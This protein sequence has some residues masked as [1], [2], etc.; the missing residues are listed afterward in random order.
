MLKTITFRNRLIALA[1][2]VSISASVMADEPRKIDVPAGE[3]IVALQK[4]AEQ[5]GVEFIYS[6]EQLK[7]YHTGGVKGEYEPKEAI[8]L[9]LRGTPLEMHVDPNGAILIA[10]PRNPE[11]GARGQSHD[12]G[13]QSAADSFHLTQ[14]DQT[15]P[16]EIASVEK[17]RFEEAAAATPVQLEEIVVTGSHI[18]GVPSVSS[19]IEL[20]QE[21]I[22]AEGVSNLGDAVRL[23]PQNFS[24]GQNP[25]VARGAATSTPSNQNFTG[26]SSINLRGLGPDAT[27]TLLNGHRLAYDSSFQAVDISTIPLDAVDRIEIVADGASAIYGSDA[28]AG[29]ANIILKRDYQ[30]ITTSARIG[31]ATD[32]GDFQQQYNVVGGTTWSS[33]GFIATYSYE[34]DTALDANDRSFTRYLPEPYTLFPGQTVNALSLSGHQSLNDSLTFSIDNLFSNRESR[35]VYTTTTE[36]SSASRTRSFTVAPAVSYKLP[37]SWSLSAYGVYGQDHSDIG[38]Q[39]LGPFPSQSE[40]CF[41]NGVAT[42][43]LS[44]KGDILKLPAG[45]VTIA[46]GGG[47]RRDTFEQTFLDNSGQAP[48]SGSRH[49][50]YGYAEIYVPVVSPDNELRYAHSLALTGAARSERYSDFGGVSTPKLGLVYSPLEDLDIKASWGRS[51][52]APTLVQEHSQSL[53]LLYD[54]STLGATG[55]PAGSTV[56]ANYGGNPSLQPERA[57]TWSVT[58]SFHPGIVSGVRL[59]VSY[60][61]ID[62]RDRITLPIP[63][64]SAALTNPVYRDFVVLNPSTAAQQRVIAGSSSG[65]INISSGDYDSASVIALIEDPYTNATQQ[66]IHGV[67][68]FGRYRLTFGASVF[69]INANGA[70]LTSTQQTTPLAAPYELAG[71]VYNPARLR[72]QLGFTWARGPLTFATQLNYVGGVRNTLVSPAV[73]GGSMTT[74]NASVIYNIVDSGAISNTELQLSVQNLTD[75]RPPY[76][77]NVSPYYVHYDSTNYSPLGRVLSFGI[78]KLW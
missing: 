16:A 56:L 14:A 70:W 37:G 45:N 77:A 25:G 46:L 78:R 2:A 66:A 75:A 7:S 40:Y 29:V 20:T 58:T 65:I 8:R 38:N 9:L 35:S 63:I 73:E 54:A 22:R 13:K 47:Y 18:T 11:P 64:L 42:G 4:L 49:S 24:G 59:D 34:D 30:G 21:D 43:E 48:L 5:S 61:S 69:T 57:E 23:L 27:L 1:C 60:F 72:S 10:T 28:V 26:G 51:F 39:V 68:A 12:E 32:H 36:S 53:A 52:K 41:C 17:R 31:G 3:L 74:E 76:L 50:Y 15:P 19:V 67:D 44:A 33:G 55:Y 71:T 6:P 62:Y